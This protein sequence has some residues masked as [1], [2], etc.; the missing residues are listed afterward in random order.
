MYNG[1]EK[2][3]GSYETDNYEFINNVANIFFNVFDISFVELKNLEN[4]SI[5]KFFVYVIMTT[6][7][8]QPALIA[9]LLDINIIDIKKIVYSYNKKFKTNNK[10]EFTSALYDNY[11]YIKKRIN[12]L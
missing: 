11:I 4:N 10:N 7:K 12:K 9:S 2:I 6:T 1:Y 5:K 3:F 8:I